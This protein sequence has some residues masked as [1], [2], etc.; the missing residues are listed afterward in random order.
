M[1]TKNILRKKL[2]EFVDAPT[3][4]KKEKKPDV[5]YQQDQETMDFLKELNTD[6]LEALLILNDDLKANGINLKDFRS[7]MHLLVNRKGRKHFY[8]NSFRL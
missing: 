1:G 8:Y 3:E 6:I 4:E 7:A 2:R 5:I